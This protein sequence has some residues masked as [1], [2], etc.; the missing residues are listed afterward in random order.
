MRAG[1]LLAVWLL[2]LRAEACDFQPSVTD[3][4]IDQM[5]VTEG[6]DSRCGAAGWPVA[7]SI[8]RGPR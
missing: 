3:V 1:L 5:W 8:D 7:R 2:A 4:S 6:D